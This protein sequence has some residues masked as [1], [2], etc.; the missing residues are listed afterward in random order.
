MNENNKIDN[1]TISE[2]NL[3][4]Y[5]ISSK[6]FKNNLKLIQSYELSFKKK[7]FYSLLN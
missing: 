4:R 5:L 6:M 1:N 7:F 2:N 3:K